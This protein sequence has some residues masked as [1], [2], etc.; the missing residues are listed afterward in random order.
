MARPF[1]AAFDLATATGCADGYPDQKAPRLWSWYLDD[2]G[3]ERAHRLA[4]LWRFCDSYFIQQ[5]S[6][7][8]PVDE[9]VY[10]KPLGIAVIAQMMAKRLYNTSEET[11]STLRGSI[12]VLEAC[13]AH[14]GIRV[15][16]GMDIKDA[17]KHLTGQRTFPDGNAKQATLRASHALG[18]NPQND[19]EADASALWALAV[20]QANPL[21]AE[22]TRAA[23]MAKE[24]PVQRK[25]GKAAPGAGPLFAPPKGSG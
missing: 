11:L 8:L 22:V 20:G 21:Y 5:K 7:G 16:R 19:N 13:A 23:H 1:I 6:L 25:K 10:E 18:W 2:A 3:S 9:V 4:Y 24:E 17:R 12:G 15:I 14:H